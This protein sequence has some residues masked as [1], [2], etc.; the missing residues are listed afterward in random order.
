MTALTGYSEGKSK[1][2]DSVSVRCLWRGDPAPHTSWL[3]TA[4]FFGLEKKVRSFGRAS[5]QQYSILPTDATSARGGGSE[6]SFGKGRS[7]IGA[8]RRPR[9]AKGGA[10]FFAGTRAGVFPAVATGQ[11]DHGAF[12]G[13]CADA[14][15]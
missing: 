4:R 2:H 3:G 1:G 6:I 12:A 7:R 13:S 10:A 11:G 5:A 9:A 14:G 15:I 8:Q